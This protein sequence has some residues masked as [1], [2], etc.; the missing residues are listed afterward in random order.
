MFLDSFYQMDQG[1]ITITPEQG[2]R[3]A[4]EVA[5]DFNPLHNPD[6]KRFC[7][8]GDLLFSL[9]LSTMGLS[10][11]MTFKY[12]GMVGKG[13]ALKFPLVGEG[14]F[15]ICDENDKS[16][17]EVSC[18]GATSD[19]QTLIEN[20]ARAYV[21]F[22]GLSFPHILV[23][24]MEKN[25]VMIN[26]ERPMVIYE[27]MAFELH[28]LNLDQPQ[29][30]LT[31]SSLQVDGKRG[32]VTLSFDILENDILVGTGRKTMTLGGLRE[33]DKIKMQGLIDLYEQ[34]KQDYL[35]VA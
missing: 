13:A 31:D 24:L 5:N 28:D 12:T 7:V 33:Y 18:S 10:Q 21:A 11:N 8:P 34:S 17:L 6:A 14:E 29:L 2:S 27:S 15:A 16:Y 22:S 26:P 19:D 4:K 35:E 30:K 3:F 25:K 9:V 20:F 1:L 23:P 32:Q